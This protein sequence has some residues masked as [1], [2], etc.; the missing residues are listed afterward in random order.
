MTF[1]METRLYVPGMFFLETLTLQLLCLNVAPK[2][3]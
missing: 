2:I 1:V 3:K